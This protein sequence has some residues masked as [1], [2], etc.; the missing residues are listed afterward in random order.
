MTFL[1]STI[2]QNSL[3]V[4]TASR[5]SNVAEIFSPGSKRQKREADILSPLNAEVKK[6]WR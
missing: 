1:F 3:G 5:Y 6:E 2:V 4:D